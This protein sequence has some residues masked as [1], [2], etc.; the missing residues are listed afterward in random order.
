MT[1]NF[2]DTCTITDYTVAD[3]VDILTCMNNLGAV[4][5]YLLYKKLLS[6]C[7]YHMCAVLWD[8]ST[9][10]HNKVACSGSILTFT[11]QTNELGF[12]N[13][14]TPRGPNFDVLLK[15]PPNTVGAFSHDLDFYYMN[16]VRTS[17][18]KNIQGISCSN[19]LST[20]LEFDN[21]TY[22]FGNIANVRIIHSLESFVMGLN[23]SIFL[24]GV[25]YF[26][27]RPKMKDQRSFVV[28]SIYIIPLAGVA[29]LLYG[30]FLMTFIPYLLGN[31]V[32]IFI[33]PVLSDWLRYARKYSLKIEQDSQALSDRDIQKPKK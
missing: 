11:Q 10:N 20:C 29:L 23:V 25:V 17:F 3:N 4:K 33:I 8:P 32:I 9:G 1:S 13:P 19:D 16:D 12:F 5:S 2:F 6:I 30:L 27:V 24:G 21:N 26:F 28:W 7:E 31:L 18:E 22:C 15:L 14:I